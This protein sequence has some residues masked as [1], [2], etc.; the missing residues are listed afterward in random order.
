M[1]GGVEGEVGKQGRKEEVSAKEQRGEK[2]REHALFMGKFHVP[3]QGRKPNTLDY[4][5]PSRITACRQVKVMGQWSS[6]P[7]CSK[8]RS[9]Y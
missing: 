9:H 1:L 2:H 7:N 5:L 8:V 6:E 3:A 4:T